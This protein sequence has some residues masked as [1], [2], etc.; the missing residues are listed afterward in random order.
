MSPQEFCMRRLTLLTSFFK[1]FFL[2]FGQQIIALIGHFIGP[3]LCVMLKRTFSQMIFSPNFIHASICRRDIFPQ[4]G[5]YFFRI[6]RLVGHQ[7]HL[8]A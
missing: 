5:C 3:P 6:F 1:A 7:D 4:H 8:C 2:V